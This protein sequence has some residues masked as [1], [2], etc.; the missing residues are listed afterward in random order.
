VSWLTR[1]RCRKSPRQVVQNDGCA[2]KDPDDGYVRIP[3]SALPTVQLHHLISDIDLTIAVFDD[4]CPGETIT[5]YTEW[6]GS[7]HERTVSVG[8]DWAFVRR[9]VVLINPNEIRTNIRL[10]SDDCRAE[11]PAS[12]RMHS[13]HWIE[14]FPWR[15]VAINDLLST[16]TCLR[17]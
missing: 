9:F 10:F 17:Q 14:S 4:T 11:L 8:W 12:A 15:Q 16:D 5:G 3:T 6:I 7:W 13:V 2:E 1:R